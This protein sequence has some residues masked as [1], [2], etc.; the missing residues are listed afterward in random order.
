MVVVGGAA[1][2]VEGV[3]HAA[4][5]GACGGHV[6]VVAAGNLVTEIFFSQL[7]DHRRHIAVSRPLSAECKAKR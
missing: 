4:R 1:A 3:C 2:A 7:H 5:G 6:D